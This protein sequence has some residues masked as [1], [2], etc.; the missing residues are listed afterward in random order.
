MPLIGDSM[1]KNSYP[2]L[3]LNWWILIDDTPFFATATLAS[4]VTNK[5]IEIIF[6]NIPN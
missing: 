5:N 4:K 2:L 6:C 1:I 3:E